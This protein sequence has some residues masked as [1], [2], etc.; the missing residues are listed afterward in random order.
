MKNS[1]AAALCSGALMLGLAIGV[2]ARSDLPGI[3]AIRGKP[4]REAAAAALATAEKLAGTG[5]WE[6]IAIGRVYY[7]SGDKARGQSLIDAR[8]S[9]GSQQRLPFIRPL[10]LDQRGDDG[11]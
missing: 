8:V 7:L 11:D 1:P 2:I 6:R 4:P 3:D 9:I 5:T 10:N